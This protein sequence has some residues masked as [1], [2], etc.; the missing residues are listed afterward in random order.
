M[1]K[2][3]LLTV[4]LLIFGVM[5]LSADDRSYKT[6]ESMAVE[7]KIELGAHSHLTF[8]LDLDTNATG[9]TNSTDVDLKV[10][11]IPK[12]T[13]N[14][15]MDGMG[16]IYGWIELKD[17]KWEVTSADGG[18]KTTNPE[19]T[20]KLFV[21]PFS[22]TTYSKPKMDIDYVDPKDD[23]VP[24]APDVETVY[25]GS[26]GLTL[27]YAIDPIEVKLGVLSRADWTDDDEAAEA[28]SACHIHD[29]TTGKVSD[30]P[31]TQSAD[32]LNADN[33]Y[34]FMGTFA[35]DVGDAADIEMK[36]VYAH[37]PKKMY[38][39]TTESGPELGPIGI[40]AKA[41][42]DLNDTIHP[43]IAFDGR[44]PE[45]QGNIPWDVGG[46]LKW[47]ISDDD[48]SYFE[49]NLMMYIPT[50]GDSELGISATLKEGD[51][52][53]GG[54]DGLGATLTVSLD[55]LTSQETNGSTWSTEV[56]A[57][58]KVS[59]IKPFFDVKFSNATTEKTSFKAG[60]EL[61]MI[62]HLTTTLQYKSDDITGTTPD[63]GEVTA[64]LKISY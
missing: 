39:A 11:L 49:T 61:S 46:G 47:D 60:L 24:D 5:S 12:S 21:G 59:G 34:A 32:D 6:D 7:P 57:H 51:D 10:I 23:D 15:G 9:F 36:A 17:Y 64:E 54:L 41:T 20:T 25:E 55:D 53:S 42:F 3:A 13:T 40:G 2:I 58:Y 19:I 56:A 52:D 33:A 30:C 31:A 18:G 62:D 35:L 50:E 28:H 8:G 45:G 38:E 37:D 1:R 4:P 16:D 63:R 44:I 14:T 27:G 48:K 22:I 29:K 26:G 43:H